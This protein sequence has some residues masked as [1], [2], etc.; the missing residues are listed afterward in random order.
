MHMSKTQ[1]GLLGHSQVFHPMY[2]YIELVVD[3]STRGSALIPQS[4][5]RE[6]KHKRDPSQGSSRSIP[7][8]Y[9]WGGPHGVPQN[10][11]EQIG[12]KSF[13]TTQIEDE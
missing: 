13:P 8:P 1:Q 5:K 7:I 3:D 2:K 11:F 12:P 6:R 10:R 9:V 4:P